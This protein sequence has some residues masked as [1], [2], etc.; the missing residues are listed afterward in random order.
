MA[1]TYQDFPGV[2]WV[3]GSGDHIKVD[4]DKCDGCGN[5][6]RVC[7][8]KCFKI[9]GKK[10]VVDNLDMCMECGAC[11]YVCAPDAIQFSWPPGGTGFR[12]MWG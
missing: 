6:V 9:S 2:E 1:N 10:A 3:E 7:L 8:A 5:C 4:T 11:W 12:T